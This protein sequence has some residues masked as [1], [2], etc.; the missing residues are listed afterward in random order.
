MGAKHVARWHNC[1]SKADASGKPLARKFVG[2]HPP[3]ARAEAATLEKLRELV[4]PDVAIFVNW[5]DPARRRQWLPDGTEHDHRHRGRSLVRQ[6]EL[7]A[8]RALPE[9]A[10]VFCRGPAS[11]FFRLAGEAE[12]GSFQS[13]VAA[14]AMAREEAAS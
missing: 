13:E 12:V 11:W 6:R 5:D 1:R 10:E 8:A 14:C 9:G 3:E 7:E 4:P 2:P